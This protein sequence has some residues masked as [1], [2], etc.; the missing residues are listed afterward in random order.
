[1]Q[2]ELQWTL[3]GV[4]VLILVA[5]LVYN[6]WQERRAKDNADKCFSPPAQ[7]SGERLGAGGFDRDLDRDWDSNRDEPAEEPVDIEQP[8]R[9]V[10]ESVSVQT[11]LPIA[12][13][14]LWSLDAR[15]VSPLEA[16][17]G[18]GADGLGGRAAVP[19]AMVSSPLNAD[20]EFIIRFPF[21]L[22]ADRALADM[23]DRMRSGQ[24]LLRIV[25]QLEDGGEWQ[26][27]DHYSTAVYTRVDVGILLAN[28][29]GPTRQ[30][31]LQNACLLADRYAT[32]HGGAAEYTDVVQAARQA[33]DLDRFC[34]E[35]DKLISFSVVVPDG[36]P[37]SGEVLA[38]LVKEQGMQYQPSGGFVMPDEAGETLFTLVN[39]EQAPFP[40]NGQGLRT[41]GVT[42]MLEVPGCKEGLLAFDHMI[43]LGKFLADKLSARVVDSQERPINIVQIQQDRAVLSEAC[44][45]LNDR[46]I[47]PGGEQALRLFA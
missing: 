25:G 24:D 22:T 28:R 33:I 18:A 11:E 9:T 45:R 40:A 35:V 16:V 32:G 39:M 3:I 4:V 6:R 23:V 36:F 43:T 2:G 29:K 26:P 14:T 13:A 44:R 5:V 8:W 27:I 21:R 30:D 19:M 12:D 20:I 37:F 1:M 46:G 10:P 17:P 31:F 34:I 15:E 47:P 38:R 7:P 42:L 41:H